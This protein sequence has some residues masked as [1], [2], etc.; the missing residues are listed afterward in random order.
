MQSGLLNTKKWCFTNLTL[1]NHIKVQ[2][3]DGMEV[4]IQKKN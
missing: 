2:N 1:T 4:L 3:L